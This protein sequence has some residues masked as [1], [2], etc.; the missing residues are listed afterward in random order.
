LVWIGLHVFCHVWHQSAGPDH[1]AKAVKDNK[2]KAPTYIWDKWTLPLCALVNPN[3][4][5][6]F[7]EL[8]TFQAAAGS[9]NA[10]VLEAQPSSWLHAVPAS[11]GVIEW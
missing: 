9:N 3:A 6:L 7:L 2:A 11:E 4:P 10:A 1:N 5:L 8:E